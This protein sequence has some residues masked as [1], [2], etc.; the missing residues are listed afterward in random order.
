MHT[1]G[2]HLHIL[3]HDYQV[4][5]VAVFPSLK[6]N[7]MFARWSKATKKN[8]TNTWGDFR[9]L[10]EVIPFSLILCNYNMN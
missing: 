5:S 1:I 4:V 9:Q 10:T 8:T 7:L 3:F 2:L 6:Q